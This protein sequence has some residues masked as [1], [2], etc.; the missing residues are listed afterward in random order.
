MEY[1][2]APNPDDLGILHP[3]NAYLTGKLNAT[4]LDDL[5]RFQW[6]FHFG[7]QKVLDYV[8]QLREEGVLGE[9]AAP[10]SVKAS[11]IFNYLLPTCFV[12]ERAE[13]VTANV[14]FTFFDA[15]NY[16]VA[17][18][19]GQTTIS[20][21]HVG[22]PTCEVSTDWE[23]FSGVL[24]HQMLESASAAL[25]EPGDGTRVRAVL[26]QTEEEL[27]EELSDEMLEAV[28]GGKNSCSSAGCG[29]EG[30]DSTACYNDVCGVATG[31]QTACASA[32]C[33]A[34]ASQDTACAGDLCGAAAGYYSACVGAVCGADFSVGP[35]SGP[36]GVNILPVIPGI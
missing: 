26:Q 5:Q 19:D 33:T 30:G 13:G 8:A 24:K 10:P 28:A 3:Q 9:E 16:T 1:I 17:I 32:S 4:N 12:P 34:D 6:A 7:P 14:Q 22:M 21:G 18:S 15:G 2:D 27:D 20:E 11:Y 29:A 35:D 25:P 31:S 36:C 23:T